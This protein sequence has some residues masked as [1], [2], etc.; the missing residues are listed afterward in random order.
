MLSPLL[1]EFDIWY[2][3]SFFI[4]EDMQV[5]LKT[6]SS[7]RPGMMPVSRIVSLVSGTR[8]G[9]GMMS[10]HGAVPFVLCSSHKHGS[11]W[12]APS[13]SH[14]CP[15]RWEAAG[16]YPVIEDGDTDNTTYCCHL[17]GGST[18]PGGSYR[19]SLM[20][21]ANMGLRDCE[22]LRVGTCKPSKGP[23]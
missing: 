6:G 21:L 5:A 2:N 9:V 16:L 1:A 19:I 14:G 13:L 3:E 23:P 18:Y 22:L 4:P 8:S 11:V 17:L 20:M 10:E 7:I 12:A 15:G